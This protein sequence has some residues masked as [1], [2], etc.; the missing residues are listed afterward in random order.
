MRYLITRTVFKSGRMYSE[1]VLNTDDKAKALAYLEEK[2]L[3]RL[4]EGLAIE[5]ETPSAFYVKRV[6]VV[7]EF[8]MLYN[9]YEI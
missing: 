3:K 8:H 9:L 2:K 7:S 6:G 4:S 1:L 5:Y